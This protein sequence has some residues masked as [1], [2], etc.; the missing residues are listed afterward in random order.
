MN[1]KERLQIIS[2]MVS[3]HAIDTQEEIVTRLLAMDIKATQ[4]TV[5]RDIK[6]LGIVKVPS[7]KGY[8]YGLPK[9]NKGSQRLKPAY[10]LDIKTQGSMVHIAVEPG[11]SA[12]VKR[13]I[14]SL[15]E[16]L[17]FS[18]V[19]DDDSLLVIVKEGQ[20]VQALLDQLK[21]I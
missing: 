6:S 7:E 9:A 16:D 8:I 20:K 18:V 13:Q 3:D 4:A 1:K 17:V 19:S 14:L 5:S 12:V 11:T 21:E 2:D 15:C 10:L